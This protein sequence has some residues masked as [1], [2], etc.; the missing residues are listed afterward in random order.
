MKTKIQLYAHVVLYIFCMKFTIPAFSQNVNFKKALPSGEANLLHITG[1]TQ[2]ANGVMWF[3]TKKGLYKYDSNSFEAYKNNPLD[4][5]SIKSN[6]LETIFA[7]S[8]GMI[9]V[10]SLGN[11]LARFNPATGL[12]AEY[13]HNPNDE[14]SLSNDTVTAILR[15]NDGNLWIGTHGG[16]DRYDE[17]TNSFIHYRHNPEN[18]NSLSSNQVRV[19]FEDSKN[20]LWVGAGSPYPDNGGGPDEG[21]LNR[22][23]KNNNTFTRFVHDPENDKSLA[24][25]KICA[26]FED[27]KGNLWVGT[28]KLGLHK[29]NGAEGT[30]ER[31]IYNS[32]EPDKF[33]ALEV[34]EQ[35]P[36]YEHIC[37]ITQDIK[38][39]FWF[40]TLHE[41]LFS[42]NSDSGKVVNYNRTVNSASGF[43]EDGAWTT[44]TSK[45]GILWIGG[46]EGGIYYTDLLH[47]NI[48]HFDFEDK[49]VETFFEESDGTFWIGSDYEVYRYVEDEELPQKYVIETGKAEANTNYIS[50]INADKQNNIWVGSPGGLSLWDNKNETFIH[51]THN[52]ENIQSLSDNTVQVIYEDQKENLWVGTI[53]GLNLFDRKTGMA[54]RYYPS[55]SSENNRNLITSVIEDYT[56]KL[57][58]GV[59]NG[60]GVSLFNPEKAEFKTYLTGN[61]ISC[62]YEDTDNVLWAAGIDGLF[63]YDRNNDIFINTRHLHQMLDV[64]SVYCMVE[65][66][67]K[68]LWLSTTR[69]IIKFNSLRNEISVFGENY[70]VDG[71]SLVYLS[72]YKGR[73]GK[74]YFGNANGYYAFYPGEFLNTFNAPDIVFTGFNVTNR[75]VNEDNDDPLQSQMSNLKKIQLQYN[76]NVFSFD[77]MQIDYANP[78]NN[79]M[80]CYLENYDKDWRQINYNQRAYYFNVPPGEYIFR[81]KAINGY[82]IW[83]EKQIALTIMPPWW[84][85]W[86]AYVLYALVFCLGVYL[87][88]TFMKNRVIKQEK[89]KAQL[90][91]LEHAR[92][93]EK[94]YTELKS[95]QAQLIQSEKMASLGELTAGIAHEIQNP[96]NFVNNFSELSNELLQEMKEELA[97][98]NLQPATELA[99]DVIQNLQKINHHGKRADAIVKGMLQHSRTSNG[100]KEPTDINALTDEYL[101]LSYHGL[102]AKDK[103]FNADFKTEFDPNLPKINVVPQDIGRVLLNLINN[104]FYVVN[105]K[106]KLNIDGYKPEVIVRTTSFNPPSEPV[107]NSFREGRGALISVSDNGPGIPDSIKDKI[108]QP[109]FTTKPTGQ[110]TGL[111]LSLSY[112]IVKAHGGELTVRTPLEKLDNKPGEGVTFTIILPL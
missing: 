65:D 47:R 100:Q 84:K 92:E 48:P 54:T 32:E 110:G 72:G 27:D 62:V 104:A 87:V 50:G 102:R 20:R 101:R 28:A 23:D 31:L 15:D 55:G 86:W 46:T 69:G 17:K 4:P 91:E 6:L 81:V 112:D 21:G 105:E 93:I 1:I 109:F 37:F 16:L 79:K 29:M 75:L 88:H 78:G 10:G 59:W 111:G 33:S 80:Y 77:F 40:G 39:N 35:T 43:E 42:Y 98:G 90:K 13:Q 52:P 49:Q 11:G 8:T 41:G 74:I 73:D 53:N 66:D 44:Y 38:N 14:S 3:S 30:F 95:T 76:E 71:S 61:G 45:D 51:Y 56:G 26:I 67:Q 63:R 108:F 5:N 57:W 103:S 94:A 106:A 2:D 12:F 89:Q 58:V 83:A 19:I 64:A 7:D 99:D 25:N 70:G 97:T 22:M 85:K 82:G 107:P 18:P 96:L 60:G 24:N 34:T 36:E 68:N 9:W